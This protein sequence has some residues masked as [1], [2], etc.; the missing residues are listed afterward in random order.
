MVLACPEVGLEG[1]AAEMHLTSS[2]SLPNE[3]EP[4]DNPGTDN[5]VSLTESNSSEITKVP[6]GSSKKLA[7][8]IP[9]SAPNGNVV[10]GGI[11]FGQNGPI[12]TVNF[13]DAA[14]V[15]AATLDF[16][17]GIPAGICDDLSDICHDIKCYE[18]A[19][20]DSGKI[21]QSDVASLALMCGNCD[22]PSCQSLMDPEECEEEPE[23]EPT[24]T[25]SAS[26]SDAMAAQQSACDSWPASCDHCC[27]NLFDC[28][29]ATNCQGQSCMD[30]YTNCVQSCF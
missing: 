21:S 1:E 27:D 28:M 17:A 16:D 26:C 25:V 4:L 30:T 18:F 20:T 10:A 3:G 8:S 22:E 9:F 5:S 2:I 7:I 6:A 23:P 19:V 29:I 11:R 12:R 24:P 14:G 15:G 13:P